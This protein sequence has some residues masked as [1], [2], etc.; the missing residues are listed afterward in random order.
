MFVCETR[1]QTIL[2][3]GPVPSREEHAGSTE[4]QW[5][6]HERVRRRLVRCVWLTAERLCHS[7][8]RRCLFSNVRMLRNALVLCGVLASYREAVTGDDASAIT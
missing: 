3:A 7:A 8:R 2:K 6:R 1:S 4:D 5:R